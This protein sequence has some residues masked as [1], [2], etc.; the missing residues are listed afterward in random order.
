MQRKSLASYGEPALT[1]VNVSG[2]DNY[3]IWKVLTL[4]LNRKMRVPL[5]LYC[6]RCYDVC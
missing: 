4:L 2:S 5:L 1:Q 3:Y 6:L